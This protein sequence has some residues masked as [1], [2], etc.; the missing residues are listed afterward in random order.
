MCHP[1]K[2]CNSLQKIRHTAI[3]E[4]G[5]SSK[6]Y[7]DAP[8]T[9]VIR[10]TELILCLTK[11]IGEGHNPPWKIWGKETGS[12]ASLSQ[13]TPYILFKATQL[14][15]PSPPTQDWWG[16]HQGHLCP[17]Q[18]PGNQSIVSDLMSGSQSEGYNLRPRFSLLPL[19]GLRFFTKPFIPQEIEGEWQAEV[20]C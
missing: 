6:L 5:I 4:Y 15:I 3:R 18:S 9:F 12:R 11:F 20:T 16:R 14:T 19:V 13:S 1:K 7:C 2:G 17:S 10:N 8:A